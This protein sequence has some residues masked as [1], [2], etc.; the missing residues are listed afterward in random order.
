MQRNFILEL[1]KKHSLSQQE[2]ADLI[3]VSRQL[4][5]NWEQDKSEPS[6][7]NKKLIATLFNMDIDE[8]DVYNKNN[9]LKNSEIKKEKIKQAFLQSLVRTQNTL[10]TLQDIAKESN[11]KKNEVQLYFLNSED[12]LIDIIKNIEK[13]IYIQL[14]H[15]LH[16]Q[17]DSLA[18]VQNRIFPVLYQQQDNIRILYQNAISRAYWN[19]VLENVFNQ[20]IDK[21]LQQRQLT[22]LLIDRSFQIYL[23][24]RQLMSFIETWMRHPT[25]PS[26][27]DIQLLFKQFSYYSTKIL[28]EN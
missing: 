3:F 7:E 16:E 21:E 23:V 8:L 17:S 15:S 11:L 19:E 28:L 4:V 1:R 12:V 14:N 13:S 2:F 22:H 20:I 6:L 25:S 18:R 24:S 27:R 26:L 5:S 9:H 10:E